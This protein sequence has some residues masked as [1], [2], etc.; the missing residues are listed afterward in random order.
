MPYALMFQGNVYFDGT[1]AE[2][3]SIQAIDQDDVQYPNSPLPQL[4]FS[5]PTDQP[6]G[7]SAELLADL[8]LDQVISR[9]NGQASLFANGTQ[10][11]EPAS[12]LLVGAALALC[13]CRGRFA[14]H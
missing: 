9:I 11:P 13:L 5:L 8:T 10:I 12:L 1:T 3:T 6:V 7:P 2:L 4:A 14:H